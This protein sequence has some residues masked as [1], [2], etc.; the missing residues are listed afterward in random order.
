MP[1]PNYQ[2]YMQPLLIELSDGNEKKLPEL[3]RAI[4]EKCKFT[5]EQLT[6][7]IPSGK[8]TYIYHWISWAKTYLV[9]AGLIG[10]PSRGI[11][12][13]S[14]RGRLALESGKEIN[15]DYLNKGTVYIVL[16]KQGCF[17]RTNSD[18]GNPEI[19]YKQNE[20]T[21]K[22]SLKIN[23]FDTDYILLKKM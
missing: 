16:K 13:I 3:V 23:D 19:Y 10:Q 22:S 9:K 21:P 15:N 18:Y 20:C 17:N 5:A 4:S 8:Q 7:R 14:E 12:V 11:C 6:A 2:T 1:I